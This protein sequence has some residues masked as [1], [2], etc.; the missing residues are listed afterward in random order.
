MGS[1]K[2][3]L[4]ALAARALAARVARNIMGK[5]GKGALVALLAD[6]QN[7]VPAPAIGA[8]MGVS[9]ERVRQ[10]RDVLGHEVRLF[11]VYPEVEGVLM[12]PRLPAPAPEPAPEP[13]PETLPV[14]ASRGTDDA[15]E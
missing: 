1:D 6:F 14:C 4:Q 8:R 12:G 3:S 15:I 11:S 10:W 7:G 13:T 2:S 5:Y 9:R